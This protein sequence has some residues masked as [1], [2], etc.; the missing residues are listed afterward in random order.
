MDKYSAA[1]FVPVPVAASVITDAVN[2]Y[3]SNKL[4]HN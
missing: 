1:R 4:W 3:H 2:K